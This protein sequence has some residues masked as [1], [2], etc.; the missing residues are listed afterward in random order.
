MFNLQTFEPN[1]FL[2]APTFMFDP[3]LFH[4]NPNQNVLD[5]FRQPKNNQLKLIKQADSY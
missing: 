3:L 5:V 2:L 1:E 4:L